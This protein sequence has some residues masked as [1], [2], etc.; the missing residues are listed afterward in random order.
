MKHLYEEQSVLASLSAVCITCG[1][2]LK[3]SQGGTY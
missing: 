2:V 1:S 3:E